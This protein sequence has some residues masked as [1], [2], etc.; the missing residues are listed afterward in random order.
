M[1]HGFRKKEREKESIFA[2]HELK[3]KICD[4]P[5]NRTY[6]RCTIDENSTLAPPPM[7]R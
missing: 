6:D 5:R 1:E 3:L 7:L 4:S 2:E